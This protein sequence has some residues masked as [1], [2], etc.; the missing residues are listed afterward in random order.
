MAD[1]DEVE[2]AGA[3]PCRHAT[4]QALADHAVADVHRVR[5][6]QVS[7]KILELGVA[8][9]DEDVGSEG[10]YPAAIGGEETLRTSADGV[11]DGSEDRPVERQVREESHAH[12]DS[13]R[14][15]TLAHDAGGRFGRRRVGSATEAGRQPVHRVQ[16]QLLVLDRSPR[17]RIVDDQERAHLGDLH[18]RRAQGPGDAHERAARRHLV[19]HDDDAITRHEPWNGKITTVEDWLLVE[20]IERGLRPV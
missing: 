18:S 11:V 15:P 3:R 1:A 19:F 6:G 9:H 14:R 13:P 4:D 12:P 16:D 20:A 7:P 8:G 10:R 17:A 2:Q 5:P